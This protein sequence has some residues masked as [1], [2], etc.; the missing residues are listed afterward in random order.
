MGENAGLYEEER[1]QALEMRKSE[2]MRHKEAVPGLLVRLLSC[3]PHA[4]M[5]THIHRER[6][7]WKG[8]RDGADRWLGGGR[9]VVCVCVGS[10]GGGGGLWD[11]R[12]H[13][14]GHDVRGGD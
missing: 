12:H 5:G 6:H 7:S 13:E 2:E 9:F 4:C 8:S 11:E 1:L 3:T 10:V 14:H